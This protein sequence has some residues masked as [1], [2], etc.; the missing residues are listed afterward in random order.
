MYADK[1]TDSMRM[2]IDETNRRREKQMAYNKEHGITPQAIIKSRNALVGM[3]LEELSPASNPRSAAAKRSASAQ[4]AKVVPYAQEY[5]YSADVATDPVIKYMS[6]EELQR[7]ITRTRAEMM[8]AAKRMEFM[9]AA[10]LRDEVLKMEKLAKA[11][12]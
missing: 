6:A 8:K 3:E 9:E 12:E 10:R 1:M 5:S 7:A 11:S 2:T 4:A